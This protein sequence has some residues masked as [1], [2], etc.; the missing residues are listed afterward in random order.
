MVPY[1]LTLGQQNFNVCE[2]LRGF[3]R[4]FVKSVAIGFPDVVFKGF[5]VVAG[6]PA[7]P[8][9]AAAFPAWQGIPKSCA[10]AQQAQLFGCIL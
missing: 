9:T 10:C 8:P 7:P 2:V 3:S 4:F 5:H 6:L 1:V